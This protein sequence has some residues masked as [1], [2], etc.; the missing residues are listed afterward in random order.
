MGK[1][2]FVAAILNFLILSRNRWS[3]VVVPAIFEISIPKTPLGQSFMLLFGSAQ[4]KQKLLH[5]RPTNTLP[6]NDDEGE[7]CPI[8]LFCKVNDEFSYRLIV[9]Y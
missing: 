3:D 4:L 1:T 2:C 6:S 7:Y 8:F 5:I 9:R